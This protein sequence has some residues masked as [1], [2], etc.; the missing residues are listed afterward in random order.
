MGEGSNL[1]VIMP[2]YKKDPRLKIDREINIPPRELFIPLGW[3]EDAQ[4]K[5]K[6]YRSFVHSELENEVLSR[7]SPF[8]SF[9]IMRG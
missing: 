1:V 5:R 3:D 8:D 4:T 2:Q 7:P 9:N 6:H